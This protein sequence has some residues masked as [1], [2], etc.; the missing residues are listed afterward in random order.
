MLMIDRQTPLRPK[1]PDMEDIIAG[2]AISVR[3]YVEQLYRYVT[4]KFSIVLHDD[5]IVKLRQPLYASKCPPIDNV[6]AA[7]GAA[8]GNGNTPSADGVTAW[9]PTSIM[10]P[11]D[12]ENCIKSLRESQFYEAAISIWNIESLR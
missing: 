3:C 11:M 9:R 5:E 4:W 10:E 6:L 12:M 7:S 8:P 2:R 1:I